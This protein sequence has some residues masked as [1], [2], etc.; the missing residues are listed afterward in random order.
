MKSI[1]LIAILLLAF[2]VSSRVSGQPIMRIGLFSD[3]HWTENPKSF[4]KTE[5]ALKVFKQEKVDAIWHM[6]DISDLLYVKAY[7]HYRQNV[8]P[9][10]FPENPPDELFVYANHDLLRRDALGGV[11]QMPAAEAFETVRKE[12]GVPNA[13]DDE[14]IV[15]GYPVLIFSQFTANAVKEK[16]LEETVAKYP[17]KTIFVLD[18]C[19]AV[20]APYTDLR[21]PYCKYPQV[22]HIYGHN[23]APLRDENSIWQG[24]HTEVSA[25]CLHNWRGYLVGTSPVSKE[26]T[27]FAVMDVYPDKI[28]YRRFSIV[29]GKECK[30]PWIIPLP[31][32]AKTAPYRRDY[33]QANTPAPTFQPEAALKLTVDQPFTAV[34]LAWPEATQG[35]DVYKYYIAV[36]RQDA[37]GIFHPITR[38]DAYSEFHLDAHLRKGSFTQAFSS[39]YFDSG[40]KYRFTV[41]PVGFFEKEGT[42]ITAD[43]TPPADVMESTLIFESRDPMKE[44]EVALIIGAKRPTGTKPLAVKDGFY[45]HPSGYVR[46]FLPEKVWKDVDGGKFRFTID[47]DTRQEAPTWTMVLNNPIPFANANNRIKMPEGA[48]IGWRYVIECKKMRAPTDVYSLLLREGGPGE[49]RINYVKLEKLP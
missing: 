25:G 16:K 13:P 40:K 34:N 6:G 47:L 14:R 36:E 32:D 38:L 27:D 17:D 20:H 4:Q 39:G 19:P 2:F 28:I 12:L 30:E 29:T 49:F 5:A 18:H 21:S 42:P 24:T 35:G 46:V 9:S 45:Q 23:H 43:F 31:F 10:F 7:R 11:E 26:N 33:R 44:L 8:F 48:N 41:T 22:I 1:I 15:K 37:D 3:T